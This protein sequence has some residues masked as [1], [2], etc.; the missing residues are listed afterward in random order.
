MMTMSK[1]VLSMAIELE[2]RLKKTVRLVDWI[3][4]ACNGKSSEISALLPI[5]IFKFL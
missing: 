5:V 4:F 2:M 3:C 1:F